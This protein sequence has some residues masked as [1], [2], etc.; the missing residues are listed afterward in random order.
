[1]RCARLTRSICAACPGRRHQRTRAG[2]ELRRLRADQRLVPVVAVHR[3]ALFQSVRRVQQHRH[4]LSWRARQPPMALGATSATTRTGRIPTRTRC[5]RCGWATRSRRRWIG[6][7]RSASPACS[8][9]QLSLR[10]DLVTFPGDHRASSVVP[11]SIALYINGVQQYSSNVPAGLRGQPDPRHHRRGPGHHRHARRV[12]AQ[13]RDDGAVV[14]GH[15]PA[16]AGPVQLFGGGGLRAAAVQRAFV[17]L[18]PRAGR[19]RIG[20]LWPG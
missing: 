8:G 13:H 14:R 20:P 9:A 11:S 1:M 2:A 17:R 10:P 15:A 18:R 12:G 7:G 3:T 4:Q 19:Q 6:R 16:G 5:A